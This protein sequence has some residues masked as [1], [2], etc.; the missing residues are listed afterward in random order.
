[1]TLMNNLFTAAMVGIASF[2][3]ERA[4]FLQE[5]ANDTYNAFMFYAAK[6]VAEFPWQVIFPTAFMLIAYFM[7][8]Y[9]RSADAFFINWFIVI[10]LAN[11]GYAFGLMFATFFKESQAAFAIVPVIL[12]PLFIVSGMFANTDRL[13]P[14]WEWLNYLSFPRHGYLGVF[15]NEFSRLDVICN[16]VTPSCTYASGW[17]VIEQMGFT[18]W[19]YWKS[20]V[21]LIV[22]QLGLR[23]IGGISLYV[24]GEKRRGKLAFTK[25]LGSRVASPRAMASA[26]SNDMISSAESTLCNSIATPSNAYH[27]G[28]DRGSQKKSSAPYGDNA[29]E[30]SVE[31]TPCSP[32]E[33]KT[34]DHREL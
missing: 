9:Y 2:P 33:V 8:H 25:N 5:Q 31:Q 17:A 34:P 6:N 19:H 13:F 14:Y 21:S 24:Q 20:F 16:P 1:M 28:S 27:S 7:I 23:I 18:G 22:Y 26:R 4:V 29:N 12:L 32:V 15:N 10:L 30:P 3:P 11:F